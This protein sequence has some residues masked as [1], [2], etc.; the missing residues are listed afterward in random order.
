MA[1]AL[2]TVVDVLPLTYAFDALDRVTTDGSLGTRGAL[3]VVVSAG[4]TL[5]SWP[6]AGQR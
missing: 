2:Q 3:D 4:A 1:Q 5:L 6:S